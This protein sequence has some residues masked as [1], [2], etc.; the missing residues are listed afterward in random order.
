MYIYIGPCALICIH[1]GSASIAWGAL[2]LILSRGN[3]ASPP[4]L[5]SP[6]ALW[7]QAAAGDA[8]WLS[9][10]CPERRSE[11]R[12]NSLVSWQLDATNQKFGVAAGAA[13][14]VGQLVTAYWRKT[15]HS[16][17]Y[18]FNIDPGRIRIKYLSGSLLS[19]TCSIIAINMITLV[20]DE[21]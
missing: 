15:F 19:Q 11:G 20:C 17:T 10:A 3:T 13:G 5:F 21:R 9:T 7:T 8:V 16:W 6:S 12:K 1:L 4:C 2:Y 18:E 14:K